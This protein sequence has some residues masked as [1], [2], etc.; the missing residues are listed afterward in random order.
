[1]IPDAQRYSEEVSPVQV[2]FFIKWQDFEFN[3]SGK[4]LF[5]AKEDAAIHAISELLDI[6]LKGFVAPSKT[7]LYGEIMSKI[8]LDEVLLKRAKK[9]YEMSVKVGAVVIQAVSLIYL[10][11]I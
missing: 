8:K 6:N 3:G 4:H 11:P 5:F 2:K 9:T 7:K 1:M 10:T